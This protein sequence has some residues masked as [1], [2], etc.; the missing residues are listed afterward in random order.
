MR[1]AG[2]RRVRPRVGVGV[3]VEE[4]VRPWVVRFR[5]SWC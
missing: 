3:D 5:L 1:R 2:G 4:G